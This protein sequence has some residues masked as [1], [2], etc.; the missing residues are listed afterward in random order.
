VI[1]KELRKALKPKENRL[2]NLNVS[3][4]INHVAPESRPT[5]KFSIMMIRKA[6]LK[7]RLS[8]PQNLPESN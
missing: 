3:L 8:L 7:M 1:M 5:K 2:V 6:T 4:S